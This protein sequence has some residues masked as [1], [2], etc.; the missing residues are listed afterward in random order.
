MGA[1]STR[2]EAQAWQNGGDLCAAAGG[3]STTLPGL[4]EKGRPGAVG[5]GRASPLSTARPLCIMMILSFMP[6][7][8][9]A[10]PDEA[11]RDLEIVAQASRGRSGSISTAAASEAWLGPSSIER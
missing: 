9:E 1:P 3:S 6:Q 11:D 7:T 5:T 8:V 2:S 4:I 10:E